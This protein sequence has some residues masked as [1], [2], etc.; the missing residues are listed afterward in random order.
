[1]S[2]VSG[3]YKTLIESYLTGSM[4]VSELVITYLNKFKDETRKITDEE[5]K[6]LD[7]IFADL[8]SFTTDTSLL[9]ED[10][11]FY[12]DEGQLKAKIVA[13]LERLP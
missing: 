5:F 6:V 12:L 1:M 9:Q 11:G 10:S 7:E 13:T 8:D 2:A 3:E 4:A